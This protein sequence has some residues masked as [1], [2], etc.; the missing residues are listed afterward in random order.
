MIQLSDGRGLLGAQVGNGAEWAWVHGPGGQVS[1][2]WSYLT[3]AEPPPPRT[4]LTHQFP[5]CFSHQNHFNLG[6]LGGDNRLDFLIIGLPF[7]G[8]GNERE[9]GISESR[10]PGG[11]RANEIFV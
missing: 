2:V 1:Q 3:W 5:T 11:L 10:N 6:D 7:L 4:G 9:T 8:H